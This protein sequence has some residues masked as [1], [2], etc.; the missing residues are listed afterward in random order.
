MSSSTISK[1]FFN[2]FQHLTTQ[3][4]QSY[5]SIATSVT[6]LNAALSG[7]APVDVSYDPFPY[8]TQ[9]NFF[10]E[11][12]ENIV[13]AKT[14]LQIGQTLAQLNQMLSTCHNVSTEIIH[15][16]EI[17]LEQFR[18]IIATSLENNKYIAINFHRLQ[19]GEEGGG[20]FSPIVGYNYDR[21]ML[22]LA[23]T[24]YYY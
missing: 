20:H 6:I 14:I 12:T 17:N 1:A 15:G 8:W 2:C 24:S 16:D 3:K 21:D 22:L 13:P 11:C 10:T 5:C 7:R 18:S 19:I 4:T 23:G 9:D